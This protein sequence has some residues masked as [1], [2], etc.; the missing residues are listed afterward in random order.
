MMTT[1]K[2]NTGNS[3]HSDLIIFS[4]TRCLAVALWFPIKQNQQKE[5]KL[6]KDY[7]LVAKIRN[8]TLFRMAPKANAAFESTRYESHS[9]ELSSSPLGGAH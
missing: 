8:F 2:K 4:Y 7:T 1:A 5:K 3:T 6:Q 9:I